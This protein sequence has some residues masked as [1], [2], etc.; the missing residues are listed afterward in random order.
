MK[1]GDV[2]WYTFPAPNKRRPVLILTRDSAIT[3]LNS[4]TVAPITSTIL[5]PTYESVRADRNGIERCTEMFHSCAFWLSMLYAEA[6][7]PGERN[8][9]GSFENAVS[10]RCSDAAV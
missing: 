1:R 7:T 6:E 3:V 4:V 10:Q 9:V 8:T 5:L 2:C